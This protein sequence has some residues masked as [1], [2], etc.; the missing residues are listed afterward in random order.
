[1]FVGDVGVHRAFPFYCVFGLFVGDVGVCRAVP[2]YYVFGLF[3]G[4]VGVCRAVP[5]SVRGEWILS[6]YRDLA[7]LGGAPVRRGRTE[8]LELPEACDAQHRGHRGALQVG[9]PPLRAGL[10]HPADRGLHLP[11]DGGSVRGDVPPA[12]DQPGH[13]LPGTHRLRERPSG[14]IHSKRMRKRLRK[15]ALSFSLALN[16]P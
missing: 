16:G 11:R 1:M 13:P 7:R 15:M 10:H 14:L 2:F 4:D 3:V 12:G 9:S 5:A 6:G 8:E